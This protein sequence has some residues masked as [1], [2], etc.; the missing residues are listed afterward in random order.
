MGRDEDDHEKNG[1]SSQDL[2]PSRLLVEGLSIDDLGVIKDLEQFS[3]EINSNVIY[4]LYITFIFQ[5]VSLK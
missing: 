1:D 4:Y 2:L 3:L 5:F